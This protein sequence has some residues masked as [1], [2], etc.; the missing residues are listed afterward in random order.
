MITSVKIHHLLLPPLVA[1]KS[2]AVSTKIISI[3]SSHLLFIRPTFCGTKDVRAETIPR[4]CCCPRRCCCSQAGCGRRADARGGGGGGGGGGQ[5]LHKV[6]VLLL[7]LLSNRLFLG[8][9]IEA[10]A[11]QDS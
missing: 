10:D 9:S 6:V 1:G 8:L 4:C 7:V 3:N 5:V 11:G 2:V